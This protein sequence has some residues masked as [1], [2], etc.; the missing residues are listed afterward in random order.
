MPQ[1]TLADGVPRPYR[2]V[3]S[4]WVLSWVKKLD[5]KASDE[6]IILAKGELSLLLISYELNS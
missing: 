6:L 3:Y 1:V 2:V 5:D 4:D